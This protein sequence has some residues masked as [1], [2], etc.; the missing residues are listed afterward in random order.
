M[1]NAGW[2]PEGI[3]RELCR[4]RRLIPARGEA[5]TAAILRK[6][7]R[8]MRHR[9]RTGRAMP[10]APQIPR[11]TIGCLRPTIGRKPP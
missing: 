11:P 2:V 6:G 10:T 3:Q 7:V 5:E 4:N 1:L 8:G 9:A